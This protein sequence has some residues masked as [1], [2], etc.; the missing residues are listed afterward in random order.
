M[1]LIFLILL[2]SFTVSAQRPVA[3]PV[4]E[5]G[6]T[7]CGELLARIDN[8]FIQLKNFPQS[9]AYVVIYPRRGGLRTAE[10]KKEFIENV[11][12]RRNF[13]I[14]RLRIVRGTEVESE[15]GRFYLVPTGAADPVPDAV[16]W[17]ERKFDLASPFVFGIEGDEDPCPAF[18]FPKYAELLRL[19]PE[20]RGHVVIFPFQG[21]SRNAAMKQWLNVLTEA[22]KVPRKQLRFFFGKPRD[23]GYTEFWIVPVR[24]K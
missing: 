4:D 10:R 6:Q 9:T 21:R 16:A 18:P 14:N 12:N 13:D 22:Y 20:L 8:L 23:W 2:F 3:V 5:F 19:N 7:S 1:K 17:P 24:S 15:M 11:F